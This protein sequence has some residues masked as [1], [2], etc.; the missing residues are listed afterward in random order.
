[1]F[2]LAK[3]IIF[4]FL[5]KKVVKS[6]NGFCKNA[7][8]LVKRESI[9][10]E[11]K[12]MKTEN[13]PMI[14]RLCRW[15]QRSK[16][17]VVLI[18]SSMSLV[19][20]TVGQPRAF[21]GIYP[22]LANYNNENE[23]GTGAVVPWAGSLW[24][25]TYGPHMP[26]GSTDKLYQLLPS[27]R[28]ITRPESIGG[29][30]A[31]RMIHRETEQLFIGPYVIDRK[32]NVRTIG[33]DRMPGR[34]TGCARNLKDPANKIDVATMEQGFYEV[35]VHSLDIKTLFKDGNVLMREGA[36]SYQRT[37]CKGVH[38]KGFY[39]GQGV[40]VYSNNG[41]DCPEA[42]VNPRIPAGSLSEFDGKQWNLV[43][44]NQF[45]EVTGS[46]GSYGNDHPATDPIW[47]LGWDFKSVV[48][49]VRDSVRGWRF[50]RLPK[51]SNSY[52]GAHGWNTEWPRIRNVGSEYLMTMHGMFW[53]FPSTFSWDHTAGLRPYSNYLKVIGDFC[54]WY[55]RLVFGCDD[56]AR[57]EFL[58][59]RKAKG[60]IAG[61]GQS[62]SNLWFTTL[63][64]PRHNGTSDAEGAVWE[65]EKVEANAVSEPFL[66]AGWKNRYMWI[67]NEGKTAVKYTLEVDEDGTN[68]WKRT[69]SVTVGACEQRCVD[70][71]HLKGEWIRVAVNKPTTT[72]VAFVYGDTRLRRESNDS[73]FSSLSCISE[74]ASIGGLL[75]ALGGDRRKLGILANCVRDGQ[76]KETGY[77]ELDG[78]MNLV[79]VEDEAYSSFIRS[80][81]A[82]PHNVVTV[83]PGSYL[84]VDERGRRW[85][86]PLG[87]DRYASLMDKAQ[88]RICREVTTERDLFNLGGTF[89]ELPAEN[90]D[91]YAKIRP[92]CTH[93]LRINDYA[94]YR[95][96]L[97][98]TGIQSSAMNSEH[99]VSSADGKCKV[100]CGTIDDLWKMG[101]PTG[102]GG[103]WCKDSVKANIPSDPYL[104][105][106]YNIKTL[107]LD[108]LGD[109][110]VIYTVQ[111]DPTG[112]GTW[113]NYAKYKVRA[114]SSLIKVLPAHYFARWIRFVAD[115]DTIA[116]A[117]LEYK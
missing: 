97:V 108:N 77:Y 68:V 22:S 91:G 19:L 20:P 105:S 17:G 8:F 90:A 89:Y 101:K 58:N 102:H 50:F 51:A 87:D 31:D 72:T 79:R 62:N 82:I 30:P 98:M 21:S 9:Y 5:T 32:G 66:I 117:W 2:Y 96:L 114:G 84:I 36:K 103:P 92:I 14:K 63:D 40:Y 59:R 11:I 81:I 45:T 25:V 111:V 74:N 113:M 116:S 24:A 60:A 43:R 104:I 70:I 33:Y 76:Q 10:Q 112:D 4:S 23:C 52:D 115:K 83:T 6:I 110:P 73:I 29:T 99:I 48:L 85:R 15:S 13:Y 46:G 57:S 56:S 78:D 100:W 1:M 69:N 54:L 18:F 49:G 95:G 47:A 41:E 80:R 38:G 107:R 3:V 109:R 37:L 39:S 93:H 44:R 61:P 86:L 88:L 55:G 42:M 67:E 16:R 53:H 65:Q 71:G 35:D 106:H 12:N 26:F 34:L 28:K 75:Y 64:Q 27:M 94:S 7:V